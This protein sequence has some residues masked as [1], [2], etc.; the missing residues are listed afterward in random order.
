MIL[1]EDI[2]NFT[3]AEVLAGF[4]PNKR[5][6]RHM[7]LLQGLREWWQAPLQ[8]TSG[9]RSR[10]HNESIGGVGRS[11]HMIF[12]TDVQPSLE[13]DHLANIPESEQLAQAIIGFS[14]AAEKVGFTGVGL[15]DSFVHLDLRPE[16]LARWDNRTKIE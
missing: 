6:W 9:F 12:A 1:R 3:W 13:S 14:V 5:F 16:G 4:T 15:Y 8:I 7:E 2:P 10:V 11:Q